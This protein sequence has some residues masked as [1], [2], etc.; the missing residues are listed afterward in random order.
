MANLCKCN[1]CNVVLIDENPQ[2]GAIDYELNGS[3]LTMVQF[4]E[5]G[6]YVWGCPKCE[7]DD[8]LIDL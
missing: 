2:I 8:Y 4:N 6:D 7:T 5:E 1:L 3:E